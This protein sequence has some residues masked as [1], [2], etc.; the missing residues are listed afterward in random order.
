MGATILVGSCTP[1]GS[2]DDAAR[3]ITQAIDASAAAGRAN[4][5]R[6][7][8]AAFDTV[9]QTLD[10]YGSDSAQIGTEAIAD[11]ARQQQV[12]SQLDLYSYDSGLSSDLAEAME[13]IRGSQDVAELVAAVC[14]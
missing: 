10:V 14:P 6:V 4:E 13:S 3:G 11:Y 7:E 2:T 5:D 9:C 1:G 8:A 12:T